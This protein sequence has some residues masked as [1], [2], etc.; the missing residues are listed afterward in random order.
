ME[1]CF[2]IFEVLFVSLSLHYALNKKYFLYVLSVIL[3]SL[4]R[5]SGILC[6]VIWPIINN[7]KLPIE[8]FKLLVFNKFN[9]KNLLPLTLCFVFILLFNYDISSCFLEPA[10]F[11]PKDISNT[12]LL[13]SNFL[14]L[15]IN[16]FNGLFV[17]YFI[18]IFVLIIFYKKTEIQQKMIF[19][20][21]TY[22]V[23]FLF[24]T[25][26]IQYE[27]RVVLTPFIVFISSNILLN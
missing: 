10:F 3:C 16:N 25:P 27:I 24:F 19:L 22:L 7:I 11:I 1:K 14:K 17:N 2:S 21:S 9:L 20:I 23:V 5:E 13:E 6:A 26:L 4:N 12:T 18:I 8:N 15:N